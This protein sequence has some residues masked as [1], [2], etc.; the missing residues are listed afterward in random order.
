M[1]EHGDNLLAWLPP[2][3]ASDEPVKWKKGEQTLF[4]FAAR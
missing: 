3:M 2:R 1:A 4:G